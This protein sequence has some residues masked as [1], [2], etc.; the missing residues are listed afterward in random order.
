MN[1]KFQTIY[2]AEPIKIALGQALFS[3]I[4]YFVQKEFEHQVAERLDKYAHFFQTFLSL[5]PQFHTIIQ[6]S[7]TR[8]QPN[9]E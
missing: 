1:Q 3:A 6:E 9:T 7:L 4:Y 8:L 2:H 5:K